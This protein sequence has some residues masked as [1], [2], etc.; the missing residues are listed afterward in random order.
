MK[1]C[2]SL[3]CEGASSRCTAQSTHVRASPMPADEG[4]EDAD[5]AMAFARRHNERMLI[6]AVAPTTAQA[7]LTVGVD[8]SLPPDLQQLQL[9]YGVLGALHESIGRALVLQQ[10]RRDA[11]PGTQQ[12]VGQELATVA[13]SAAVVG[14]EKE[15]A[16]P[17]V[18]VAIARR[19]R[20]QRTCC[21]VR[22]AEML[23][24]GIGSVCIQQRPARCS[25]HHGVPRTAG[26]TLQHPTARFT[27]ATEA[28]ARLIGVC[29]PRIGAGSVLG[30][31]KH[32]GAAC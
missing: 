25:Q 5:V 31:V 19:S 16:D 9:L 32:T 26:A 14:L 2:Y 30:T 17:A 1:P 10:R 21:V 13:A 6:R 24:V 12:G 18:R 15:I 27:M 20:T 11:V 4:A 7:Q 28:L 3:R 23:N 8:T 22:R 29:A